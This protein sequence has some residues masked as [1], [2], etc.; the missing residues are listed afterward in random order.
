MYIGGRRKL[1]LRRREIGNEVTYQLPR[2]VALVSLTCDDL[3]PHLSAQVQT[4][5]GNVVESFCWAVWDPQREVNLWDERGSRLDPQQ[6]LESSGSYTVLIPDGCRVEPASA[7]VPWYRTDDG[8]L[9]HLASGWPEAIRLMTEDGQ[10]LWQPATGEMSERPSWLEAVKV[11]ARGPLTF[12]DEPQ[13]TIRAPEQVRVVWARSAGEPVLLE[14]AGTSHSRFTGEP[15]QPCVGC[16]RLLVQVGASRGAEE[17]R[18]TYRVP[19]PLDGD[20]LVRAR[21]DEPGSSG[22]QALGP[23]AKIILSGPPPRLL[24]F[25]PTAQGLHEVRAGCQRLG[26]AELQAPKTSLPL[27][28]WSVGLGEEL[29]LWQADRRVRSLGCIC[30]AR[31]LDELV[32]DGDLVTIPW[33]S[34]PGPEHAVHWWGWDGMFRTLEPCEV[35]GAFLAQMPDGRLPR[36]L[37]VTWQGQWQEAGTWHHETW[38]DG[39]DGF[40]P[41]TVVQAAW[42]R[43]PLLSPPARELLTRLVDDRSTDVVNC[44]LSNAGLPEG[45]SQVDREVRQE[46]SAAL[47]LRPE[48]LGWGCGELSKLLAIED[49]ADQLHRVADWDPVWVDSLLREWVVHEGLGRFGI[50]RLAQ[51]ISSLAEHHGEGATEELKTLAAELA[52]VVQER[53]R[54]LKSM[55]SP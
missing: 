12:G 35:D 47:K 8:L 31:P 40:G 55:P 23:A 1:E 54:W 38:Y 27:A 16:E 34:P 25:R 43:L 18:R 41:E 11:E 46:V 3:P 5:E 30:S 42:L 45:L 4:P 32:V 33:P 19:L 20:V 44:W 10:L 24:F 52:A 51:L 28:S 14:G 53:D 37:A 13:V 9:I 22:R 7:D 26:F 48:D 29:C 6:K 49:P 21:D 36:A 50:V 15:V 39:L 17:L 2:S